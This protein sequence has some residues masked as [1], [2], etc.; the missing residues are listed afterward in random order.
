[1]APINLSD[2]NRVAMLARWY[3]ASMICAV[4]LAAS[5][6]PLRT[7]QIQITKG[8]NSVYLEVFPTNSAPEIVFANL[9]ISIAATFFPLAN[10]VEYVRDPVRI[11]F[12][13]EGWAVWYAPRRNDAFLTDLHGIDGNRAYL[14]YADSDF[15][16]SLQGTVAFE[17]VSWKSDSFNH[18][19]FCVDAQSPPTFGKFFAG[20]PAHQTASVYRLVNER[21]SRV[22]APDA[23]SMK[24]GEACWVY[25]RGASDFQGPLSI[26]V[27][28][29]RG[30]LFGDQGGG[31]IVI[32]NSSTDPMA[33][34]TEL[35]NG[36]LP[37]KYVL[38][39]VAG[40]AIGNVY[41]DLPQVQSLPTM[42]AGA[43]SYFALQ[44]RREGMT[45]AVQSD[46][47]KISADNGA[48][49]WVPMVSTRNDLATSSNP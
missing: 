16:W 2:G 45:E 44:V 23:T 36:S 15:T 24:S 28:S 29:G 17:R 27:P 41:V 18:L 34:R 25:C 13:K 22:S 7:Q 3:A 32:G 38:T 31:R 39:G 37:L 35:S 10:S 40:N 8:W 20:S 11:D 30:M 4:A 47:L 21:W 12:K 14:I 1:M 6:D 42:E 9:P 49:V 19:G 33:V 43:K 26:T 5:A 46:L 48:V